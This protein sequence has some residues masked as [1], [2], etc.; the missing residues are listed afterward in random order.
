MEDTQ[1]AT[2]ASVLGCPAAGS[3]GATGHAG[4][5]QSCRAMQLPVPRGLL[6]CRDQKPHSL[7]EF[8]EQS[9][10]P[11]AWPGPTLGLQ[12]L[13]PLAR[14]SRGN[15]FPILAQGPGCTWN[16]QSHSS[17]SSM[18]EDSLRQETF[19]LGA[20]RGAGVVAGNRRAKQHSA[21]AQSLIL[22]DET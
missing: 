10:V 5:P 7:A 16:L 1:P 12:P 18:L 22:A 15:C 8:W 14:A 17:R 3:Q 11:T 21:I 4:R 2:A 13:F 20:G 6:R 19:A 9:P